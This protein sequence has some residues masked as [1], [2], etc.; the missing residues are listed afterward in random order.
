MGVTILLGSSIQAVAQK[1]IGDAES[2]DLLRLV[3]D[4]IASTPDFKKMTN[5]QRT[6]AYDA[7][8]ITGG[9]IAGLDANAKETN[10]P[11]AAA[12]ARDLAVSSL[13]QFG[14]KVR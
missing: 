11:A 13:A 10:D 5:Q 14:F 4:I 2:E 6:A 3:N 1:E 9:L 12:L 7:F 8:L